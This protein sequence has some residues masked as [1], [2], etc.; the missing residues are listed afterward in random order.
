MDKGTIE[1]IVEALAEIAKIAD[2]ATGGT[3]A[4]AITLIRVIVNLVE[5]ANT[6][7]R[8]P[9]DARNEMRMLTS[10]MLDNDTKADADLEKKFP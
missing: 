4:S 2:K 6:G 7:K 3:A 1:V 5:E 8:D 10:S 9:I